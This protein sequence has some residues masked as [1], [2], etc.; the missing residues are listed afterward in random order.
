MTAPRTSN[1]PGN[2]TDGNGLVL[3]DLAAFLKRRSSLLSWVQAGLAVASA[4]LGFYGGALATNV[5]RLLIILAIVALALSVLIGRGLEWA[6]K[7]VDDAQR[8]LAARTLIAVK[9]ALRPVA[10]LIATMP[11]LS[12]RRCAYRLNEVAVQVA[13]SMDLILDTPQLRTAVYKLVD[14]D[15][16]DVIA[17]LG[18]DGT[19]PGIFKRCPRGQPD[20]TFEAL[21]RNTT[22]VSNDVGQQSDGRQVSRGYRSYIAVP[23]VS[24]NQAFGM[25]S[26]DAPEADAFTQT[27]VDM[28]VFVAEML[29]IAFRTAAEKAG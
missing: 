27:D 15:T 25:L 19:R 9:Q 20:P 8:E 10:E 21:E 14:Q 1:M 12:A 23:I 26:V 11:A 13:G 2:R 4:A 18:G 28:V 29:A 24:E 6:Q 17:Y 5:Q 22:I 16:M 7:K 3:F